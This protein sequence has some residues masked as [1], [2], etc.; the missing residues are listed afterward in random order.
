MLTIDR[1]TPNAPHRANMT[2]SKAS[3]RFVRALARSFL[4]SRLRVL[5]KDEDVEHCQILIIWC[6]IPSLAVVETHVSY[7]WIKTLQRLAKRLL[8][9]SALIEN[10]QILK[11]IEAQNIIA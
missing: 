11:D 8:A 10:C 9:R 5:K 1:K 2:S 6:S 7:M 3:Q 4:L